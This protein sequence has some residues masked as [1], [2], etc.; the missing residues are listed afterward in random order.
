MP[1][2]IERDAASGPGG[3]RL[4]PPGAVMWTTDSVAP[5]GYLIRDG[6]SVPVATY[7]DLFAVIGYTYGGAGAN[8]NLPDDRGV[9]VSGSGLGTALP[10]LTNHAL[11]SVGGEELHT[12]TVGEL[13]QHTHVQNSHTHVQDAHTHVQDAHTHVQDVHNHT[14]NSHNHTQDSHNHTQDAHTHT[15]NS[16]NH[17]QDSHNHTQNAHTHNAYV[18]AGSGS[19]FSAIVQANSSEI[20]QLIAL[21]TT[22]TNI[23]TTATNQAQTAVNQN[24]TATNQATTATN[25]ATTAVNNATTATNQNTTA[26]NQNTTATNQST[27]AVNQNTG[28]TNPFNVIQPTRYYT[29]CIAY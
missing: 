28:S 12:M 15:Q 20:Q 2:F 1:I 27:T 11:G 9:V 24:T 29:P 21:A 26:V 19:G 13:V 10:G 6:S 8:F 3:G 25:Q 16:H 22:A 4:L 18:N 14:Q 5:N 17:T 23:A 7:P